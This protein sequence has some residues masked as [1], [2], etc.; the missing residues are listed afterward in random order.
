MRLGRSSK[1]FNLNR[2]EIVE[3]IQRKFSVT[4]K[5]DPNVKL[6]PEYIAYLESLVPTEKIKV[7]KEVQEVKQEEKQEEVIATDPQEA[8]PEPPD[9]D[10]NPRQDQVETIRA[11]KI[12][13]QGVKVID[14]IDLPEP[15]PPEM[16]EIDGVMYEKAELRKRKQAEKKARQQKLKRE[17]EKR[18]AASQKSKPKK[19]VTKELSFAEKKRLEE[20][21]DQLAKE[22][23]EKEK[24]RR[25]ARFYEKKVSTTP[26]K[27]LKKGET[28]K[29]SEK[30]IQPTE[31][32]KT[33]SVKEPT[34]LI[35]RFWKW[36][37]TY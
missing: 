12:A 4:L 34:S 37:T 13:L 10:E 15:P 3:I 19:K 32:I 31:K 22:K 26:P 6:Q 14:K 25:K 36:L 24:R 11:K 5:N 1:T 16:V 8:S 23:A 30:K 29:P 20:R 21:R 7:Q 33:D 9:E 17:L 28:K 27:N 35:Q 2:E 18:K